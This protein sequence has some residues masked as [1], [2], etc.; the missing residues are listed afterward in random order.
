MRKPEL[1]DIFKWIGQHL[2]RVGHSYHCSRLQEMLR[3]EQVWQ[4]QR[5]NPIAKIHGEKMVGGELTEVP[6]E[7]NYDNIYWTDT[8]TWQKEFDQFYRSDNECEFEG[9][10]EGNL[11]LS[12][13]GCPWAQKKP[14]FLTKSLFQ[15][16][17]NSFERITSHCHKNQFYRSDK[18]G[19]KTD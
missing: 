1:E 16:C 11:P 3:L 7:T 18:R 13:L 15:E 17:K 6:Q 10:D 12:D 8:P 14:G 5:W 4:H 2:G 19:M 9:F